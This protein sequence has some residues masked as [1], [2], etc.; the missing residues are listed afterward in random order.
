MKDPSSIQPLMFL[1]SMH[2]FSRRLLLNTW[3]R[4]VTIVC[5]DLLP[6]YFFCFH[7]VSVHTAMRYLNVSKIQC[8][9]CIDYSFW[10]S[11]FGYCYDSF[12]NFKNHNEIYQMIIWWLVLI[13]T[14]IHNSMKHIPCT[15]NN[16]YNYLELM[17]VRKYGLIKLILFAFLELCL[18]LGK[19]V[20]CNE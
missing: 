12:S 18:W 17:W 4:A 20:V 10:L 2:S 19:L 3:R 9:T 14:D 15:V 6:W 1:F 7:T 16:S 11:S 8:L 13:H 5:H